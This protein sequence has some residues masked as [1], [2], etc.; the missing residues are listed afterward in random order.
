MKN[1]H[2]FG[3]SPLNGVKKPFFRPEKWHGFAPGFYYGRHTTVM[4]TAATM[5]DLGAGMTGLGTRR[6]AFRHTVQPQR[7][8]L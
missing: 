2:M 4:H 1:C 3:I 6:G 7:G 8:S 5:P